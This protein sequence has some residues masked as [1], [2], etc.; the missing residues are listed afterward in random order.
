M[1]SS[2]VSIK[3]NCGNGRGESFS[4][5]YSEPNDGGMSR[6]AAE[7]QKGHSSVSVAG[8][9]NSSTSP[10][11]F[12]RDLVVIVVFFFLVGP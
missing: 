5:G 4:S 1:A 8:K 11:D 7:G 2:E 6:S 12:D 9:G 10:A 3:G